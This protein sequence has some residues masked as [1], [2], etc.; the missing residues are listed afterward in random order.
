MRANAERDLSSWDSARVYAPCA[1]TGVPFAVPRTP[2][3]VWSVDRGN[4]SMAGSASLAPLVA[5]IAP[6]PLVVLYAL[7][8]M[9][10]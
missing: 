6:A 2:T 8:A 10:S 4:T 3:F 5:S 9:S 1:S 7:Q